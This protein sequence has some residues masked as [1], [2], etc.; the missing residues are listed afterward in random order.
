[1]GGEVDTEQPLSLMYRTFCSKWKIDFPFSQWDLT[2]RRIQTK[3]IMNI[4]FAAP[5]M[6]MKRNQGRRYR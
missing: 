6:R 5:N 3:F 4:I 2:S 1:M